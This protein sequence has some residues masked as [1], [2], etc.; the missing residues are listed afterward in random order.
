MGGSAWTTRRD[1]ACPICNYS[2]EVH[3]GGK[4]GVETPARVRT[5][6]TKFFGFGPLV[7][8]SNGLFSRALTSAGGPREPRAGVPPARSLAHVKFCQLMPIVR[9]A[10]FSRSAASGSAPTSSSPHLPSLLALHGFTATST[11]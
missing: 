7:A 1:E 2:S 9:G 4:S 5:M 11:R 6:R 10:S 3:K 8:H